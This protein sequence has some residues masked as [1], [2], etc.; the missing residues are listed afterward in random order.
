V[1]TRNCREAK[2]SSATAIGQTGKQKADIELSSP[3][4]QG[5]QRH[6]PEPAQVEEASR[7]SSAK[8]RDYDGLS[9]LFYFLIRF[10]LTCVNCTY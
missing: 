6:S 1:K 5:L 7:R 3:W 10:L 4:P 8:S 2:S 9:H